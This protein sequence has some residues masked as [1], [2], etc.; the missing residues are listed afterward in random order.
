MIVSHTE[1]AT[2]DLLGGAFI[3]TGLSMGYSRVRWRL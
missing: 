3:I 1:G 2:Q